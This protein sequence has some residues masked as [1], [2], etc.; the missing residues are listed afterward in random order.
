[1]T[2]AVYM[3]EHV[4][5]AITTGVR[6][7]GVDVLTAQEDGQ[8]QVSDNVLL[9]RATELYT[10]DTHLRLPI[11]GFRSL[12]SDSPFLVPIILAQPE[13]NPARTACNPNDGVS[14]ALNSQHRD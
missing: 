5:R 12:I 9:D 7:R 14:R 10:G 8:R 13:R 4:H 11:L 2:V 1:M 3:D 6:L